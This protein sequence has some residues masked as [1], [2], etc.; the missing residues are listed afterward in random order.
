[1]STPE[2]VTKLLNELLGVLIRL[3]AIYTILGLASSFLVEFAGAVLH[4]RY[5]VMRNGVCRLLG[6]S[7]TKEFFNHYL[8]RSLGKFPSYIPLWLFP[9]VIND[10]EAKIKEKNPQNHEIQTIFNPLYVS[11]SEEKTKIIKQFF[12][13]ILSSAS[14]DYRLW[15]FSVIWIPAIVFTIILRLDTIQ[16]IG[17][18]LGIAQTTQSRLNPL[19]GRILTQ[20]TSFLESI[21][22]GYFLTA[23]LICIFGVLTFD[24]LNKITNVKLARTPPEVLFADRD[25]SESF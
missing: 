23:L 25:D 17:N 7:L 15:A 20:L 11:K 19:I 13:Q 21:S 12:G 1:M 18:Y 5:Y 2:E 16:L 8:I 4:I 24:I 14:D 6:K 9:V 10:I 22:F 3:I